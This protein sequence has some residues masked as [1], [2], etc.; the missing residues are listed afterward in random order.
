MAD[1]MGLGKT[2]SMICLIAANQ[3]QS[4]LTSPAQ[5]PEPARQGQQINLKATLLIVS[6]PRES[7]YTCSDSQLTSAVIQAWQNQLKM[8]VFPFS[9][10]SLDNDSAIIGT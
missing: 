9:L 5:S 1:D 8:Y 4:D 10:F 3:A 6:P 7:V 2:L